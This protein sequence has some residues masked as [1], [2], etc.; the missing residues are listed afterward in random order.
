VGGKFLGHLG[1]LRSP[2]P[3]MQGE[4]Q[5]EVGSQGANATKFQKKLSL[6]KLGIRWSLRPLESE[7]HE[8]KKLSLEKLGIRL[9]PTLQVRASLHL[10]T[11]AAPR[12][13]WGLEG[14]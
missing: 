4:V 14:T 9:P 7:C 10:S 12:H 8:K 5:I 6:E 13:L 3:V 11:K 1:G 2:Q